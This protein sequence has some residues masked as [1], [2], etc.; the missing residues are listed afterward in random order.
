VEDGWYLVLPESW[1]TQVQVQRESEAEES[2]VTFSY[3]DG[4]ELREFLKISAITGDSREI[5][6]VRGGRF[7][8][9]RR[10]ETIYS[11]ELLEANDSWPSGMTEDEL[12]TAF[13]L[14]TA[15]WLAGDN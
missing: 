14:I 5:K 10:A 3:R 9:N 11:A 12:R 4:A 1:R 7:I 6:A 8:L 13:N 2:T 15:D